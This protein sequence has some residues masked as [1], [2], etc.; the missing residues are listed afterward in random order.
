MCWVTKSTYYIFY[1]PRTSRPHQDHIIA[2]EFAHI[3]LGHT[4]VTDLPAGPA[5][6]TGSRIDPATVKMMLGRSNYEVDEEHDAEL[7]ASN[8][9]RRIFALA[10]QGDGPAGDVI[11][12]RVA[13]T[14]LRRRRR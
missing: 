13:R 11:Q 9:Q 2:H 4:Q 8:L 12:E 7:L 1:D 14:L 6:G 10:H 5:D 3:L